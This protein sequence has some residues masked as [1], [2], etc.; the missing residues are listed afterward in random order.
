MRALL[1]LTTA[2]LLVACSGA[3]PVPDGGIDPDGGLRTPVVTAVAP[4]EGPTTGGTVVLVSGDHFVEGAVV[5]F[6][7]AA[8]TEVQVTSA[9]RISART[10]ARAM[11]GAVTVEV[12]NPDGQTAILPDGFVYVGA[13]GAVIA[14]ARLLG[15][16]EGADESG[17]N[18][19]LVTVRAEVEV[20]GVTAGA[21]KG[22]GVRAQVGFAPDAQGFSLAS[23]SW[24]EAS[25]EGDADAR[26]VYTGQVSVPG[27]TG[28]E[29]KVYLLAARFSVD[30]GQSWIIADRDGASNGTQVAQ[31]QRLEVSRNRVDWCR[32]GGQDAA[33]PPDIS[34]SAGQAGPLVFVQLYEGGV[35]N[36]GGAGPG[37]EAQLGYGPHGSDPVGGSWTWGA[38]EF[39]VDTGSGA[40][41][42]W[43][44]TLPNPGEGTYS[45]AWR[46][47][48]DGGAWRYC[49][50]DGSGPDSGFDL[51]QAGR[52]TVTPAA[53]VVDRCRL[54]HPPTLQTTEGAQS[55]PV[56]GWV[57]APGLTTGS[58]QGG[59]VSGE[60]GYG[61]VGTQPTEASWT[62]FA[63][64]YG[65]DKDG[66]AADEY[67]ATFPGPAPGSYHYAYRFRLGSGAYTYCDLDGSE[68]GGYSSAQAG[69]LTALAPQPACRLAEVVQPG[70]GGT[71]VAAIA[72]GDPLRARAR[73][74]LPGVSSLPGA[75]PGVLAQVGVGTQLTDASTS[76][77]WGWG[78]ATFEADDA[79][80][81]EDVWV[82]NFN[83][84]YSG[85]RA[86]SFR[87]ST[88]NG[89][90]WLYCD[91]DGS[92]NGYQP[93][94]QHAVEVL[95]HLDLDYCNLQFPATATNGDVIYGQV[96]EAGMTPHATA[97]AAHADLEVALGWGR[98]I[99][100]PGL[101]WS[102]SPATFNVVVG[103]NDEFAA[104]L[105]GLPAGA[106]Q[107][108][109]RY[110]KSSGGG[111]YYGD[112][113]GNGPATTLTG[114]N[115]QDGSGNPNLGQATVGP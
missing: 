96:Y 86:V 16:A 110:R 17:A 103:Q 87:F 59:G 15:D 109:F 52:L 55:A 57:W 75:A 81:G 46:A 115:G 62:W 36:M 106:W 65:E 13:Q 71:P 53:A 28:A 78:P 41:D 35:T 7:G 39:N 94:Q 50:A 32:L 11:T 108:A 22:D 18:P 61:P 105:A 8:G 80:T 30:S 91:L 92:A 54:Q 1:S 27:A 26:D 95:K 83:A 84:A 100:D 56:F 99:E 44:A 97:A 89:A 63:A 20:A 12:Q 10:P 38:G 25:Y 101:A 68:N 47:R 104:P 102:W 77:A 37:L 21:G 3:D 24:V 74:H 5:R 29:T 73:L 48:V 51:A 64:S 40:N 93:A 45:W 85:Q 79:A 112:L 49:D 67:Q 72:S 76:P 14:E 19:V 88:D 9:R 34:L 43:R 107:Y 42:E 111:W 90:S 60:V 23:L 66:D 6:G 2:L 98:E 33:P 70:A 58:G 69:V 4:T 113:D 31:L 114:F 82:A